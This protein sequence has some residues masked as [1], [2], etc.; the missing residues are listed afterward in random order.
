MKHEIVSV[1]DN[2]KTGICSLCGPVTV[3][4]RNDTKKYRCY[5]SKRD[6]ERKRLYG[7]TRQEFDAMLFEQSYMCAICSVSVDY[8]GNV[9]HDHV[10]GKVRGILCPTCNR[11]LGLFQDD[12]ELLL[13]SIDYLEKSDD[14]Q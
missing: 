11:A 4:Y 6:S 10:T 5:D 8:T 2:G 3:N 14:N 13:K 7:L 9:D 1:D 12:R